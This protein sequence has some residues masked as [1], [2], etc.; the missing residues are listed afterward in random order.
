GAS[1]VSP[2]VLHL[3]PGAREWFLRWL[4]EAHPELIQRY[5]ELYGHR[6]YAPRAYQQRIT[7]QVAEFAV[8]YRVGHASP[9]RARR[10]RP[11]SAQP[12]DPPAS[13]QL[14]LL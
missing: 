4:R 2:I 11:Q 10:I 3:R 9:R 1:H 12:A 5:R 8:R 14:R 6:A 7:E 13:V